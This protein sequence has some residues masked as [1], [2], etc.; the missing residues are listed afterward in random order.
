MTLTKWPIDEYFGE[1]LSLENRR[2]KAFSEVVGPG[3]DGTDVKAEKLL[4]WG[5]ADGERV[6]FSRV[7]GSTGNLH[8]LAS[9][10][11][12]GDGSLEVH[13]DNLR[14][15]DVRTNNGEFHCPAP[16]A[17]EEVKSIHNARSEEE[18]TKERILDKTTGSVKEGED[19]EDDVPVMGDPEGSVCVPPG[20]LSGEDEDDDGYYSCTEPSE[21][22]HGQEEPIAEFR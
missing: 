21:S 14:G 3:S 20:V 19:V 17:D 4:V 22:S 9:F 5:R 18:V 6:E 10:V 7:L 11:V 12:K 8:P 1:W 15:K 2:A 16:N 13:T